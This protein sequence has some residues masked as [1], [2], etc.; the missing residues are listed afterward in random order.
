MDEFGEKCVQLGFL[1][2]DNKGKP[3]GSEDCLYLNV[4][5]PARRGIFP[6]M[7]WI[8]GG[9]LM[10][11]S[12]DSALYE[13]S[14]LAKNQDVVVVTFNYRLGVFGFLALQELRGED[15]D[16]SV[17]GYGMMDQIAALKWVRDNIASFGGDPA[18]VTIFGESAGGWSVCQLLASPAA[19]GLFHR[20]IQQ[21]GGCNRTRT[22]DQGF[23]FGREFASSLGC[24]GPDLVS[25]LRGKSVKAIMRVAPWNAA[26]DGMP[27]KVHED[28][29]LLKK[30]PIDHIREGDYNR[31]PYLA[32]SNRDEY[33]LFALLEPNLPALTK[34]DYEKRVRAERG[35]WAE[36]FLALYPAEAFASPY[37]AYITLEADRNPGCGTVE[38]AAALARHQREVYLYRFDFDD[39]P[40]SERLGAFHGLEIMFVFTTFDQG[41]LGKILGAKNL[42][43]AQPLGRAMQSYWANFARSGDPNGPGLIPWPA[44]T[45]EQKSRLLFD[46]DSIRVIQESEI[47]LQRCELWDEYVREV[48]RR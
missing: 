11:G 6:V 32:G 21:S 7:V 28:G 33:K 44:Y 23:A 37:E 2:Q 35:A 45:P 25:C 20:A 38:A 24:A 17:G 48:E 31:T 40:L 15:P 43:L 39:I 47:Q 30:M 34:D 9:G 1:D 19:K 27:F 42:A 12:G 41:W 8:H 22:L 10:S 14:R 16:G 3:R 26:G 29:F 36:R 18:N 4:W 13:G 5:R 46:S